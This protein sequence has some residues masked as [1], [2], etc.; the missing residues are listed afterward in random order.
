S[1]RDD[2]K[3]VPGIVLVAAEIETPLDEVAELQATVGIAAPFAVGD[4]ALREPLAAAQELLRAPGGSPPAPLAASFTA[5]IA[6]RLS[7]GKRGSLELEAQRDTALLE[8]RRYQRRT[9]F[10][11]KHLRALLVAPKPRP[12][13]PAPAPVPLYLPD[14]VA[15]LLPLLKR[16]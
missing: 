14:D 6:E 10:G 5:R 12:P 1:A 8:Q 3:F 13:A 9:V 2:G 15:D 4:E 7:R 11:K 16:F